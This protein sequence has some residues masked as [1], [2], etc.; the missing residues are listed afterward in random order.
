MKRRNKWLIASLALFVLALGLLA[1]LEETTDIEQKE[2][3]LYIPPVSIVTVQPGNYPS[4]IYTNGEIKPRWSTTLKAMVS[5][6]CIKITDKAL[7]GQKVN[8]GDLLAE[9]EDSAYQ[10]AVHEAQ[11]AL[12]EAELNLLQEQK[13][14]AQARR[15]WQRSGVEKTPSVLALNKPQLAL[16]EKTLTA[17]QSRLS[18]AKKNLTHTQ[19]RAPFSGLITERHISL[20]QAISE[21]EHLLHLIH[22]NQQEIS[23][24]LDKT[25][26]AMLTENW[27]GE[28]ASILNGEGS[29]IGQAKMVRGGDFLA[30]DT[31]Q[32]R[33]F[34]EIQGGVGNTLPTGDFV[35]VQLPGRMVHNALYILSSAL[36]RDGFI[37]YVDEHERLRK[38]KAEVLF[39]RNDAIVVQ[40]PHNE[41]A[42]DKATPAWRVATTPLASFLAG[43][44]VAPVESDGE[45]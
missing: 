43:N 41:L 7:A 28:T 13:K 45:N 35:Q 1:V 29:E 24:T 15:D 20:G 2:A 30:A 44:R 3:A 37:W 31:R 11:Q 16:A 33:L 23:V 42:G 34:L 21:G 4:V 40:A 19:I 25:Q 36:T 38:F 10:M 39:H 6:E 9:I 22:Q 32:Y 27:Q 14:A 26:W 12:A 5:G 17:A 8:R 18:A